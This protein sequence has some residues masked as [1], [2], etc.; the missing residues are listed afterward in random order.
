MTPELQREPDILTVEDVCR[1]LRVKRSWCYNDKSLPW[2]SAGRLKR[3]YRRD[4]ANYIDS[5]RYERL[6][7]TEKTVMIADRQE[8]FD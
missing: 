8:I 1:I 7:D 4:L 2:F 6:C 3:I 5:Q